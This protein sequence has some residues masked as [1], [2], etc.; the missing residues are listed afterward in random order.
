MPCKPITRPQAHGGIGY[1]CRSPP[2]H[3]PPSCSRIHASTGCVAPTERTGIRLITGTSP[4][5]LPSAPPGGSGRAHSDLVSNCRN[6]LRPDDLP[7]PS[8]RDQKA[9]GP[10]CRRSL[11][12]PAPIPWVGTD[13]TASRQTVACQEPAGLGRVS[14]QGGRRRSDI[15]DPSTHR[16]DHTNT[17]SPG[18]NL[19]ASPAGL[20]PRQT[21]SSDY[22]ARR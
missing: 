20:S 8:R 21:P 5:T 9:L 1:T 14:E 2:V 13:S 18:A 11:S 7:S 12:V 19:H 6:L 4:P 22:R 3:G 10:S 15:H 17:D 16:G